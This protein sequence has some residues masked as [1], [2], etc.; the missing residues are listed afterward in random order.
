MK[1]LFPYT[2]LFT[3]VQAQEWLCLTCQIQRAQG[4]LEPPGPPMKKST[5]N[6]G[7]GAQSQ[8]P[9]SASP[10]KKEITAPG[11]P[12]QKRSTLA[13]VPATTEA[14]KGLESHKQASPASVRKTTQETQKTSASQK[15]PNETSQTGHKTSDATPASQQESGRFF[16]FGGAKTNAGKPEESVTGKMFGFGSSIF[17]SASTLITSAVQDEPKITPPVSPKMQPTK[18]SKSPAAARKLEQ[19]KKQEQAQQAKA[20]PLGQAK[21][22]KTPPQTQ[23]VAA[24]SQHD[25]KAH[26]TTCPICKM[27]LNVGSKNPP[28]Y[29][30][31]TDCKNTVCNQCGF[32]PM[33]NVKEV[34]QCLIFVALMNQRSHFILIL[35]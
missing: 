10:V 19:E 30:T 16:G 9:S 28:N 18:E 21:V 23:K 5:P 20:H 11:S 26:Q 25:P 27:V 13:K 1:V 31:C 8:T 2:F 12:Q 6:K 32:N 33:P 29:D 15:S 17:S 14:A 22:D 34:R 7:S 24:T 4:A 3:F 35:S